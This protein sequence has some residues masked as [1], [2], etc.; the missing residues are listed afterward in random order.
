MTAALPAQL[1]PRVAAW[2]P[3]LKALVQLLR[4]AL[5][6]AGAEDFHWPAGL[7]ATAFGAVVAR[8][9]VGAYLHHHLAGD[10]R[11]ALPAAVQEQLTET[12]RRTARLALVR[13]AELVRIARLFANAGI[14]FLSVKGPLLAQALYGGVGVRHAGDLDLLIAPARL[15]DADKALL[16]AGCR[17][18]QPDFELTPR[19]RREYQRLKHEFEYFND[20]TGVRIEVEWRLEGLGR[21]AFNEWLKSGTREALGGV[22]LAR[23]P[24]ETEALYLFVH[25]AGHEWFRLFWLVDLARL[26]VHGGVDWPQ[27]MRMARA[28]G[29]E[30]SVWQGARLVEVLFG[31]TVPER[32]NVPTVHASRV[33]WLVNSALRRM[34]RAEADQPGLR[35]LLRQTRYQL[36][37]R[38]DWSAKAAVLRPRLMSPANWKMLRLPDRL[39]ALYYPAAPLLWLRRRMRRG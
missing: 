28:S 32:V 37:L 33:S 13:S 29:V 16:A 10:V 38:G 20:A 11:A 1:S 39:F 34:N 15:G 2:P 5:G 14:P 18:S 9:R 27:V 23:L 35:E 19:Q 4:L 21:Q 30:A 26:L 17:R 25:G 36:R 31:V 24:A 3:E 7:D 22:E 8:H 6:T 12:A